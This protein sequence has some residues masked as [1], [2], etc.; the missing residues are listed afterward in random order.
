MGV[1][2]CVDI[3]LQKWLVRS[4]LEVET[5]FRQVEH[6]AISDSSSFFQGRISKL[7]TKP[8]SL[9]MVCALGFRKAPTK[10]KS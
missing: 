5:A 4:E 6:N 9:G 7:H 2:V 10:A 3:T 1:G 8:S